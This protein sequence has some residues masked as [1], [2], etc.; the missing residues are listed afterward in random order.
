MSSSKKGNIE[1]CGNS[2]Y[3]F[4]NVLYMC[5]STISLDHKCLEGGHPVGFLSDTSMYPEF[6][7]NAWHIVGVHFPHERPL[8]K[9]SVSGKVRM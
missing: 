4:Y 3:V 9:I 6:S 1:C 5:N 2:L 7:K 8:P